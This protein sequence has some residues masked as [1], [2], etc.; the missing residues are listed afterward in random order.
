MQSLK[1]LRGIVRGFQRARCNVVS[2]FTKI[3][4]RGRTRDSWLTPGVISRT[5]VSAGSNLLTT[6]AVIQEFVYQ[7]E[8]RNFR[9]D[10]LQSRRNSYLS[11]F[12]RGGRRGDFDS[13]ARNRAQPIVNH[14]AKFK[15]WW[16]CKKFR[17]DQSTFGKARSSEH[18]SL[19][20]L[21]LCRHHNHTW[22]PIWSWPSH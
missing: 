1:K 3:S 11:G 2:I 18:L 15:V 9:V 13:W 16:A 6:K 20:E 10:V 7:V 19:R 5:V 21:S 8:E 12:L 22:G 4:S 14:V 17:S